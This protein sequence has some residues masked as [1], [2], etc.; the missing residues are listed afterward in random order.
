[1][2]K[3]SLQRVRRIIAGDGGAKPGGRWPEAVLGLD[4]ATALVEALELKVVSIDE[5]EKMAATSSRT[6]IRWREI[7][8][9]WRT[10]LE[11]TGDAEGWL[12]DGHPAAGNRYQLD[13]LQGHGFRLPSPY[14]A[15]TV[16]AVASFPISIGHHGVWPV[17]YEFDSEQPVIAGVSCGWGGSLD[18]LWL[19]ADNLIIQKPSEAAAWV[20]PQ[21]CIAHYLCI[22]AKFSDVLPAYRAADKS[23]ALLFGF[24][25]NL[26]HHFWNDV[27][28]VEKV[29]RMGAEANIDALYA[30][31]S[32]W[33]PASYLFP[34]FADRIRPSE[35]HDALCRQIFAGRHL[36]VRSTASAMDAALGERIRAAARRM[37]ED[38]PERARTFRLETSP[39]GFTLFF[40][41][42]NHNKTWL[43]QVEG[44]DAIV[45]ELERRGHP[46]PRIYLDGFHDCE[47]LV[48]QIRQSLGARARV[49]DGTRRLLAETLLWAFECD[50]FIAV[51]GSGLVLPTWIADKPGVCHGDV[52]H[53]RQLDFWSDVRR[54]TWPLRHPEAS[55][56][57]NTSEKFYSNYHLE[58]RIVVRLFGQHLEALEQDAPTLQDPALPHMLAHAYRFGGAAVGARESLSRRCAAMSDQLEA[59]LNARDALAAEL[60]ILSEDRDGLAAELRATRRNLAAPPGDPSSPIVDV[61]TLEDP[62][63]SPRN[64]L[65]LDVKPSLADHLHRWR[66]FGP[67]M[68]RLPCLREDS[69]P[70]EAAFPTGDALVLQAIIATHAPTRC[71]QLGSASA[72]EAMQEGAA[73]FCATPP[74]M[75]LIGGGSGCS[76]RLPVGPVQVGVELLCLGVEQAPLSVFEEL[77]SGDLLSINTSHVSK[78]GSDVN[79][80]FFQVLPRLQL[81]INI[82]IQNVFWPFEYPRN[83]IYEQCRSWNEVYTLHALLAGNGDYE[84]IF[85]ND[86]FAQFAPMSAKAACPAFFQERPNGLWLKKT[87][88]A[89]L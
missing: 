40:N 49:I 60:K 45:G 79:Y 52:M 33:L 34:D 85:F 81:G 35:D 89:A 17:V 53:M 28:G 23:V 18:F 11:L 42:R 64:L 22:C 21:T 72:F 54:P 80:I 15:R 19:V 47:P 69:R 68:D 51:I 78:T 31:T 25:Y 39:P 38:H 6:H 61:E 7:S 62:F 83:F 36:I 30:R 71:V 44:L 43:E 3:A 57:E 82:Y 65:P 63:R 14:A 2:S 77:S 1:M 66:S 58:P 87:A 9:A 48:G 76:E 10:D 12:I 67:F 29:V 88:G 4:E 32:A 20:T 59:A 75:T 74:A 70:F 84:I 41:M 13:L 56:I 16:E 26:G 37:L 86:Y 73:A 5:W 8:E 27:A 24:M 46:P 50:V 55:E